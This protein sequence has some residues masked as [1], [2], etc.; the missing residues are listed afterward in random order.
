M[1]LPEAIGSGSSGEVNQRML[2]IAHGYSHGRGRSAAAR[3][4]RAE[5]RVREGRAR[6]PRLP[7]CDRPLARQRHRSPRPRRSRRLPPMERKAKL[8]GSRLDVTLERNG[9]VVRQLNAEVDLPNLLGT[10][11]STTRRD[12]GEVPFA[13]ARDGRIYTPT[14][15]DQRDRRDARRRRA[16]RHAAGHVR[17]AG[18]GYRDDGRSDR[19]RT[20]VRH[21]AAG[22]RFVDGAAPRER[23]QRRDSALVSSAS[24]SLASFRCP[25]RLTRNLSVLS[26]GVHRIAQGDYRAR[27]EV[28]SHDEI[29][30]LATAFN[31]MADDVE[32]HRARRGRPGTHPPRARARPADPARHA[33]ANAAASRVDRGQ[34]RFRA[35]TR[36]RRRLLQLLS[37]SPTARS[38]CSSA[39]CRA[40]ASARRC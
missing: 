4:R 14:T 30:R 27:V 37:R 12:R 26:E 33:A 39:T 5:G 34:G 7:E 13:V 36:S 18:L 8:S 22:R 24:R 6:P 3:D 17:A 23:A 10:V 9:Q 32:R 1:K 21:R 2:G 28:R 38:R 29:G 40:R 11:F 25:A 19:L 35:G 20:E 31:Q 16:R 15:E